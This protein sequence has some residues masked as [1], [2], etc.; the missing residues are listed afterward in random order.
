MTMKTNLTLL[1]IASLMSS[2]AS[3]SAAEPTALELIR[4]GNRYVGEQF[5]D[6][7]V[8]IRSEKSVA[9]LTPQSWL[10]NYRSEFT[11]LK[12]IEVKFV[13]GKMA[14]VDTS[15]KGGRPFELSRI[16]VDSDKALNVATNEPILKNLTLRSSKMSLERIGDANLPAWRVQ[17]W[18]AKL[19]N[20]TDSVAIGEILISTEDGTVLKNDLKISKV[21]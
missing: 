2:A 16:K 4:E 18:A 17:L 7:V 5:K 11:S 1:L 6:K 15:M 20:P 8:L 14:D 10:L 3:V 21:D 9:T 19:K 13:G 12:G